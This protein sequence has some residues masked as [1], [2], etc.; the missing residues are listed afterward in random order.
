MGGGVVSEAVSNRTSGAIAGAGGGAVVGGFTGALGGAAVGAIR[1]H[2]SSDA[3]ESRKRMKIAKTALK[4]VRQT[5]KLKETKNDPE[6]KS[7]V[8][9]AEDKIRRAMSQEAHEYGKRAGER[10]LKYGKAGMGIGAG[11]GAIVGGCKGAKEGEEYDDLQKRNSVER[12]KMY[13]DRLRMRAHAADFRGTSP[14][15]SRR[16][17]RPGKKFHMDQ[18]SRN[19]LRN[20]HNLNNDGGA[21]YDEDKFVD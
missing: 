14:N 18:E 2:F 11:V 4:A 21:W 10:M 3:K 8:D 15:S 17:N 19:K 13:R 16:F 20:F 6:A 1:N 9:A 7:A 5:R 12:A